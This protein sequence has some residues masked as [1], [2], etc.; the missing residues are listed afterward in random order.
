MNWTQNTLDTF[1]WKNSSAPNAIH[2]PTLIPESA[3]S[4]LSTC[5]TFTKR[6]L[7]PTKSSLNS[8]ASFR[9]SSK[10]SKN[11]ITERNI[12]FLLSLNPCS[13]TWPSLLLSDELRLFPPSFMNTWLPQSSKTDCTLLN[14]NNTN[15]NNI[16]NNISNNNNN[17]LIMVANIRDILL[18]CTTLIQ[19]HTRIDLTRTWLRL[20]PP[21][22]PPSRPFMMAVDTLLIIIIIIIILL[23]L[24][25][26]R[27]QSLQLIIIITHHYHL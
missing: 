6:A 21:T 19:S 20:P 9:K 24:F 1:V 4:P 22:N 25:L 14:T 13:L 17:N 27:W 18:I 11:S 3:H 16:S 8:I 26:H 2:A 5:L 10:K 23:L 7:S 15:S 12:P